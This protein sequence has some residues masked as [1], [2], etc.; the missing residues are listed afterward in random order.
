MPHKDVLKILTKKGFQIKKASKKHIVLTKKVSSDNPEF[1][2]VVV[3]RHKSLA[4]GTL[5]NI[6]RSSGYTVEEFFGSR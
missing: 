6:I 2:L 4:L 1:K 3:P 5:Q